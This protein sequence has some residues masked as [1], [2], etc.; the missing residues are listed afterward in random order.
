MGIAEG[1]VLSLPLTLLALSGCPKPVIPLGQ[2]VVE[3][4]RFE[5]NSRRLFAEDGQAALA[6]A[7][8]TRASTRFI[9]LP[10]RLDFFGYVGD[11]ALL[12]PTTLDA[13]KERVETWYAHHGWFDA[14]FTGW[15]IRPRKRKSPGGAPGVDL[16]G[17]VVTGER[18]VLDGEP[19]IAGI[20]DLSGPIRAALG[21]L[22][23][24]HAGDPF[25]L[26]AYTE[27]LGSLQARLQ[28]RGYAYAAV[29]GHVTVHPET[30]LVHVRFEV[31]HGRPC[32]FGAI[33]VVGAGGGV[34]TK[35]VL[36]E[37]DFETGEG[38]RT[39]KLIA[40]RQ[41][42]YGLGVFGTVEVTPRLDTPEERAVPVEVRLK[43]RPSHTLEVGFDVEGESNR[44]VIVG[45]AAYADDDAFKKL[46]RWEAD[47]SLGVATTVDFSQVDT[48]PVGDQVADTFT[49]TGS[50]TQTL[51]VPHLIG[52]HVALTANTDVHHDFATGYR[53]IQASAT[54]ALSW[55]PDRRI[56]TSLGYRLQYTRYY[57]YADLKAVKSSRLSVSVREQSFL[58][59]VQEKLT[60]DARDDKLAPTRNYYLSLAL[61]E[62]GGPFGGDEGFFRM[63][64][65]VRAYKGIRFGK[66]AEPHTVVAGRVGAGG[67]ASYDPAAG[68]DI[69]ERLLLGGGTTVRGW[70]EDRLG[71]H[72]CYDPVT[73]EAHL[74]P[75]GGALCSSTDIIE[76]I[77]GTLSVYGN[78]EVRQDLPWN[79]GIVGFLDV[80]R[81]WD[82]PKNASF[83][84]LQW[85]AGGGL[86]YRSP[87][88]PIRVDVGKVITVDPYFAEEPGWQV[89]L[90]IGEAF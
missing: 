22:V 14:H 47:A 69:S 31:S 11:V 37:L 4:L 1:H 29:S 17:H 76:G 74:G 15:E 82:D 38:F 19:E 16:V 61:D 42:L 68:V 86:R 59:M 85:S 3:D 77:G 23:S 78:F 21:R 34:A 25:D 80:G 65:D 88:G 55:T 41:R 7:V 83:A 56:T 27:S 35:R 30:H 49:P 8:E 45:S 5:G 84:G 72:L 48:L 2:S 53:L 75:E 36:S 67:I 20:D 73:H 6:D 71:P 10:G 12:D 28:E 89:H 63:A 64:G 32:V 58:S 46:W 33:T 60:W 81:V 24:L 90:G 54:P 13:D 39:S 26:D 62:A 87:I 52:D 70:A 66:D 44:Q 43:R 50:L 18:S 51:T 57:D 40:A 9:D 79:F